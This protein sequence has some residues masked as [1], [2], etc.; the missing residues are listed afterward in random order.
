MGGWGTPL[1]V[2]ALL[3]VLDVRLCGRQLDGLA[4]HRPLAPISALGNLFL[5]HDPVDFY[6]KIEKN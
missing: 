2:A 4:S 5:G 1:D 6:N 3:L